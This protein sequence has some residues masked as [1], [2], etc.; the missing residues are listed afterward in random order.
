MNERPPTYRYQL[1]SSNGKIVDNT[2]D[3]VRAR[4][5]ADSENLELVKNMLAYRTDGVGFKIVSVTLR[6]ISQ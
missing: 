6:K 2:N 5:K 4:T 3:L 1:R